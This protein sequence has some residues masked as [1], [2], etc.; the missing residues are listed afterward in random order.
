MAKRQSD[1]IPPPNKDFGSEGESL[2]EQKRTGLARPNMS[3][4]FL[5]TRMAEELFDKGQILDN[6]DLGDDPKIKPE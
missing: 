2:E 6:L 4:E 1:N 5:A 3:P